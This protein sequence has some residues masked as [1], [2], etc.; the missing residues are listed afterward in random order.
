MKI[1]IGV[2]SNQC[3]GVERE[4]VDSIW[5]KN[6]S[7]AKTEMRECVFDDCCHPNGCVCM[8]VVM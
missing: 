2:K 6:L 3:L 8:L 1:K 5:P 4:K 7:R